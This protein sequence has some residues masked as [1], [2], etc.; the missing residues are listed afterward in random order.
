[1]EGAGDG[2]CP[3]GAELRI[4]DGVGGLGG[5][6]LCC[7]PSP[8][9]SAGAGELSAS[10]AQ[11]FCPLLPLALGLEKSG[12]GRCGPVPGRVFVPG[13]GTRGTNAALGG[14]FPS[15]R[16]GTRGFCG[17]AWPWRIWDGRSW[18]QRGLLR[19]CGF[20]QAGFFYFFLQ[21]LPFPRGHVAELPL[22]H[23]STEV[24]AL[25]LPPS[26][27]RAGGTL[28]S[29]QGPRGH[30][31][32]RASP[33]TRLG[34]EHRALPAPLQHNLPPARVKAGGLGGG[35]PVFP[36]PFFSPRRHFL[37]ADQAWC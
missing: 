8:P 16:L 13:T 28:G 27:Q 21:S 14:F 1:M 10:H 18:W 4:W 7:L 11:I 30:G 25:G 35:L 6:R 36:Q 9:C 26:T 22:L 24:G 19:C 29:L 15:V 20:S 31:T 5:L 33:G 23:G 3:A 12:T 17:L 2:A 34:E 32:C 37:G